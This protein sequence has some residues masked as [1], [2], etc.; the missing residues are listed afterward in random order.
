MAHAAAS[1]AFENLTLSIA[2]EEGVI[3]A[4][5]SLSVHGRVFAYVDGDEL[6]VALP[7]HRVKDL[8]FRE[9]AAPVESDPS[10]VRISDLELWN[11]LAREGFE[12]VGEPP[13]GGES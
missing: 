4:E 3:V 10:L 9:V 1:A 6:V 8:V 5:G 2:D 12:F 11:E 7:E 13:V